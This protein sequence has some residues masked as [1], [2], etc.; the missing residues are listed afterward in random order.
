MIYFDL[1]ISPTSYE[2]MSSFYGD[3]IVTPSNDCN[4][5]QNFVGWY[6]KQ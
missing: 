5:M 6:V 1:R 3:L 2:R 4:Y